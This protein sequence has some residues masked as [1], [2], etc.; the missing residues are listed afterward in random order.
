MN[1]SHR[2]RGAAAICGVP[3]LNQLLE[4]V[5]TAARDEDGVRIQ[6][7]L[8]EVMAEASSLVRSEE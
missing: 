8:P 6:V 3:A 1:Q 5:E 2:L 4:K 7:L